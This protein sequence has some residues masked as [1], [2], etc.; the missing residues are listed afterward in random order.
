MKTRNYFTL[1]ELLVVIA[2]IAILASMLLPALGKAREKA[3]SI[4]C[5]SNLKQCGLGMVMYSDDFNGYARLYGSTTGVNYDG[6]TVITFWA[7][8]LGYGKYLEVR[9]KNLCCPA[10]KPSSIMAGTRNFETYGAF[11]PQKT[12]NN[13]THN[14]FNNRISVFTTSPELH[15]LV[16]RQVK[17]PAS[18][19]LFADSVTT[20]GLQSAVCYRT[21]TAASASAR[22]GGKVNCAFMDG[23]AEQNSPYELTNVFKSAPNDYLSGT[24]KIYEINDSVLKSYSF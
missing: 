2:I 20:A 15:F 6:M 11:D 17:I 21:M 9:S 16:L 22:H 4:S 18:G 23:H 5:I 8:H 10:G 14:L 1:I 7:D 12:A 13:A 3:R 24:W 19:I